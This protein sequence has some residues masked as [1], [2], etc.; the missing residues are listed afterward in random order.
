MTMAVLVVAVRAMMVM[1]FTMAVFVRVAVFIM[2]MMLP[3]KFVRLRG[4][5]RNLR[6]DRA[7]VASIAFC[8]RDASGH[9]NGCRHGDEE[10]ALNFH[11]DRSKAVSTEC[12]SR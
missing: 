6:S 4:H 10:T 1:T 5:V 12:F 11:L 9:G 3:P 7:S 8:I 2:T